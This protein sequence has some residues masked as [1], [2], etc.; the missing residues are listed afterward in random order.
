MLSV[1]FLCW[2]IDLHPYAVPVLCWYNCAGGVSPEKN[3]FLQKNK[4]LR[5]FLTKWLQIGNTT[6][7]TD[8]YEECKLF[9]DIL[10][11]HTM[12]S[13]TETYFWIDSMTK[14]VDF[15]FRFYP[16]F[17]GLEGH[18]DCFGYT[19]AF[20]WQVAADTQKTSI[21]AVLCKQHTVRDF[22]IASCK[23][24]WCIALHNAIL[25]ILNGEAA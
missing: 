12:I 9:F 1:A 3:S 22:V 25:P 21:R 8:F 24:L 7:Y 20:L 11:D 18:F 4:I 10:E 14:V 19:T 5:T 16:M 15:S 6:H 17:I 23:F 2:Y 13:D